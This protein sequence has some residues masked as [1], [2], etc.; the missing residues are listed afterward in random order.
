MFEPTELFELLG[1]VAF[2][3]TPEER[4]DAEN[5]IMVMLSSL[6][7][8]IDLQ[9]SVFGAIRK[10][11]NDPEHYDSQGPSLGYVSVENLKAVMGED[12]EC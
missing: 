6:E 8:L 4:D 12:N 5:T 3:E 11:M 7:T 10:L 1:I 2:P 9:A